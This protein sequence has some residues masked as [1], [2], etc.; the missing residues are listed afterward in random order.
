M[1]WQ[2]SLQNPIPEANHE[3]EVNMFNLLICIGLAFFIWNFILT[4]SQKGKVTGT[5]DKAK[6]SYKDNKD[7]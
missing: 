1:N 2:M 3:Q 5:I 6:R 7:K 4:K